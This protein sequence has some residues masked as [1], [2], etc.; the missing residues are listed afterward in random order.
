[1]YID[2]IEILKGK[3]K[4][5]ISINDGAITRYLYKDYIKSNYNHICQT[6]HINIKNLNINDDEK[7]WK[8]GY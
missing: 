8:K 2:L 1:M 6:T 7:K 5:L 3:W 4:V